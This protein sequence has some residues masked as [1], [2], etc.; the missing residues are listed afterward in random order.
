MSLLL[1]NNVIWQSKT[2]HE[3]FRRHIMKFIN[4]QEGFEDITNWIFFVSSPNRKTKTLEESKKSQK[5]H[6]MLK[7]CAPHVPHAP[8][9][10]G[11]KSI[12]LFVSC[13]TPSPTRGTHVVLGKYRV[14]LVLQ[15]EKHGKLRLFPKRLLKKVQPGNMLCC[16]GM[17]HSYKRPMLKI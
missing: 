14:L 7:S 15:W 3:N 13:H 10:C 1:K 4:V 9:A 16:G 5:Q 11:T 2:T 17:L 12:F 8:Q 6:G